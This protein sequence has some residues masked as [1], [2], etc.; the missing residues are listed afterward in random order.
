MLGATPIL[1]CRSGDVSQTSARALIEAEVPVG[2]LDGGLLAWE[3]AD[4]P[5]ER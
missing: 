3:G 5:I 1:Y 4:L 2:Y